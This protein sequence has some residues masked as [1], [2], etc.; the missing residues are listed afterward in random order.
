MM[1][2]RSVEAGIRKPLQDQN[3]II[4]LGSRQVGKTTLLR[5][6]F[7]EKDCFWLNGD[8]WDTRR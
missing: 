2:S 1:I 7:D 5:Q 4:L 3:A 6:L 8:D